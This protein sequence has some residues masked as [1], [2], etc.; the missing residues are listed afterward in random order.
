[1]P[2]LATS[3]L[4][5]RAC[6]CLKPVGA[7]SV[8]KIPDTHR[9]RYMY[10]SSVHWANG[11]N[12]WLRRSCMWGMSVGRMVQQLSYLHACNVYCVADKAEHSNTCIA[13]P[14]RYLSHCQT[15]QLKLSLNICTQCWTKQPKLPCKTITVI[16]VQ[17]IRQDFIGH[18]RK[19]SWCNKHPWF[20]LCGTM[21]KSLLLLNKEPG[22]APWYFV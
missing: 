3:G 19:H 17:S 5:H 2:E 16:H 15:K 10:R 7:K 6:Y 14:T 12:M 13:W 20:S 21:E 4:Q 22:C 18:R 1:M 11:T 9:M 8:Q